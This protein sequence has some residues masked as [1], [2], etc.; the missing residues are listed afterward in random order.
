MNMQ[1]SAAQ[2]IIADINH[3]KDT[4]LHLISGG[5]IIESLHFMT[6]SSISSSSLIRRCFWIR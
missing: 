2:F 4:A 5:S 1:G 3:G 6:R